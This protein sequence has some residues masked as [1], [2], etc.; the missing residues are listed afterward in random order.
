MTPLEARVPSTESSTTRADR[1]VSEVVPKKDL[2]RSVD[3]G[4]PRVEAI[5]EAAAHCFSER[6]F[7]TTTLADIGKELG[8]RKSI[9]HYYFTNKQALVHEVQSFASGRY[10]QRVQAALAPSTLNV[11]TGSGSRLTRGLRNLFFGTRENGGMSGLN[12]ELWSAG[13]RDEEIA[14]RLE[15]MAAEAHALVH[16]HVEA[17]RPTAEDAEALATLTLAVLDGLNVRE[18]RE[19]SSE[20]VEAAF[21][22]FLRLLDS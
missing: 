22:A 18:E 21:E 5:L 12:L 7:T 8:L 4:N 9:V 13:R 15:R 16:A 20:G 17:T 19:G 11:T 14:L 2:P 3:W 10:L 1:A 6:G